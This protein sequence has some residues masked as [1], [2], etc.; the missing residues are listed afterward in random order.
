MDVQSVEIQEARKGKNRQ[1]SQQTLK[2][3]TLAQMFQI[4]YELQNRQ[5]LGKTSLF[6]KEVN[7][8]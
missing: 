1:P 8:S 2:P 6:Q 4:S 7:H 5:N 3:K